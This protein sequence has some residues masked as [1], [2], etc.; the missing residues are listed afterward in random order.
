MTG[1][2]K[3][4]EM[5]IVTQAEEIVQAYAERYFRYETPPAAQGLMLPSI[6]RWIFGVAAGLAGL[7]GIVG[8][9][10]WLG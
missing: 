3:R 1:K 2:S 8:L 5:D 10:L 7:A 9:L 6:K 4:G